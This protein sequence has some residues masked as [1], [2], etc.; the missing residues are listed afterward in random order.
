MK[1]FYSILTI[2]MMTVFLMP[3]SHTYEKKS[4]QNHKHSEELVHQDSY[5]H[6][7]TTD[8]CSPFC[9]CGCCGQP[10]SYP[11]FFSQYISRDLIALENLNIYKPPFISNFY[12]NIWRPP[13][14]S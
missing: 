8:M 1:V 4:L 3:C 13:K 6:Q 14:I 11:S 7:E 10:I 5:D 2:Y 9:V 12:G